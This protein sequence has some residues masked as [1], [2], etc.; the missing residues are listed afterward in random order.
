MNKNSIFCVVSQS[1]DIL[2]A[3]STRE[4]AEYYLSKLLEDFPEKE[5]SYLV[6]ELFID[7]ASLITGLFVYMV[8]YNP[9][10]KYKWTAT[11]FGEYLIPVPD[12][13]FNEVMFDESNSYYVFV[14]ENSKSEA[15]NVGKELIN[16]YI[17]S[18]QYPLIFK[19]SLVGTLGS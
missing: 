12:S 18:H 15:M 10:L 9:D 5:D 7:K 17:E 2:T 16:K 19:L 1:F 4:R 14:R 13:K 3:C 11:Y 6:Q 8:M